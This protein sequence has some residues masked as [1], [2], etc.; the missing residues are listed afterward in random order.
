MIIIKPSE[1]IFDSRLFLGWLL[2]TLKPALHL[3]PFHLNGVRR[4][5]EEF[6]D[7]GIVFE[8]PRG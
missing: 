8:T 5:D 4:L 2:I 3:T 1:L 6:H 7:V